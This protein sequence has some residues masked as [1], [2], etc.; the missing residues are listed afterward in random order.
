[1]SNNPPNIGTAY[2]DDGRVKARIVTDEI[3]Q[4]PALRQQRSNVDAEDV[5]ISTMAEPETSIHH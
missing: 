4:R 3:N 1:M 2:S 5:L